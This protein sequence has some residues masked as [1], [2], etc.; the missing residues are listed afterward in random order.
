MPSWRPRGIW[1]ETSSAAVLAGL[2]AHGPRETDGP[3]VRLVTSSGYKDIATAKEPFAPTTPDW[4]PV[5]A[6]LTARQAALG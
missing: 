6:A 5:K 4:E 2:R 3:V 1:C